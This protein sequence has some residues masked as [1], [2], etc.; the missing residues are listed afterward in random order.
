MKSHH[1]SRGVCFLLFAVCLL[2]TGCG[3]SKPEQAVISELELIKQLDEETI[4]FFVSYEDM[5]SSD[6]QTTD[7]GP[8]TTEAVQLFFKNF[9]YR[10][11]SSRISKNSASVNVRL[12]NLDMKS[13]AH[14]MCLALT[15]RSTDPRTSPEPLSMNGYFT[16]LRDVLKSHS[17]KILSTDA[18]FELTRLS[19]GSWSI[20]NTDSLEDQLVGGFITYLNDPYLVTPE[21]ILTLTFDC[22]L[23]FSAENWMTYLD[24]DDIFSTGS[25]LA[26][27][28]D[29]ELASQI[30]RYFRYEISDSSSSEAFAQVTVSITSLNLENVLNN[31]RTRLLEYAST[32]E[33]VRDTDTELAE[34]TAEMLYDSLSTN[35][36][37]VSQELT[38][39]FSN[40][41]SSWDM[42]LDEDFANAILGNAS[43]AVSA[44]T[45]EVLT[46]TESN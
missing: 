28:L 7:I 15:E 46:E 44:L 2:F 6:T 4:K 14:D 25:S 23:E 22:F 12:T 30:A 45:G 20:Q 10:I 9:D 27:Q 5:M 21:E 26:K 34:K 32:T 13:L 37:T 41:G 36:D 42:H 39:S 38:I 24:M 17:Y 29:T 16:L 18:R 33:A 8:E 19:D 35:E 43:E 40:N 3:K 31:C 11:L 1:L